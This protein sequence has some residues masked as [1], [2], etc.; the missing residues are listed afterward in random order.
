MF[1][2]LTEASIKFEAEHSLILQVQ[3]LDA[4]RLKIGDLRVSGRTRKEIGALIWYGDAEAPC[5]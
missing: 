1:Q 2:S 3:Y 4:D 5:K